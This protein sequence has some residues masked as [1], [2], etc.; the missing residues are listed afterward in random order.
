MLD[1]FYIDGY[2]LLVEGKVFQ[3][4]KIEWIEVSKEFFM[5]EIYVN[6]YVK[7]GMFIEL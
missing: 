3:D 5:R 6:V 2:V 7:M 1:K 4:K